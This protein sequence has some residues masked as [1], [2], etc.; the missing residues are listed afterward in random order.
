M[1]ENNFIGAVG[2][3]TEIGCLAE[4]VL[5]YDCK[6]YTYYTSENANFQEECLLY[7]SL[8]GLT[9]CT[10]CYTGQLFSPPTTTNRVQFWF[11]FCF[12]HVWFYAKKQSYE[13][14]VKK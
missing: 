12:E 10:G 9:G 1:T 11:Q 8:D 7:S 14:A 3:K 5:N 6:F 2:T 13:I 4:C